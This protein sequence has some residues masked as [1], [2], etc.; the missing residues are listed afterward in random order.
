MIVTELLIGAVIQV[1]FPGLLS[2]SSPAMLQ[3]CSL[4]EKHQKPSTGSAVP[5]WIL[6][7]REEKGDLELP[8]KNFYMAQQYLKSKH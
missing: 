5:Q 7:I 1:H 3:N 4:L 8:K 6:D 2:C